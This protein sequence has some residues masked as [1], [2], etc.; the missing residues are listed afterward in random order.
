MKVLVTGG[1]GFIGSNLVRHLVSAQ[2]HEIA[3]LDNLSVGLTEHGLPREARFLH[4]D[5][6]DRETLAQ[7]LRGVD[8]VV[9]L[10]ALSG[11]IDSIEDPGPSFK[12]N[13]AGSFRLLELARRL[14]VR[15]VIC[16]STGGALLGDVAPPIS[17]SHAPTPLSPYGASKLAMEGYCSAFAGAYGLACATLRFSNVYGPFSAH[18]KSVVAAFIKQ[19]LRGEPLVVYGDATQE[20]DYLYVGDLVRGVEAVIAGDIVGTYQLGS[21]RPTSLLQLIEALNAIAT[22][23]IE[24]R[25]EPARRGEVHRTWCDVSK[26]HKAFG[27]ATPTALPDGLRATWNWFADN[28]SS[29]EGLTRMVSAD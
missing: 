14:G 27:F 4:G 13:V 18:K 3:V 28:C 24:V 9:H 19:A 26:A 21:G 23:A 11:V 6:T 5:F 7:A 12:V 17:E 25:R 16:A 29:W 15:K 8:V 20:R 10:A 2:Q 22:R 1:A